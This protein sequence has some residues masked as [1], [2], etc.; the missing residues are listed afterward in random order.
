MVQM[1]LSVAFV[2]AA[3]AIVPVVALPY[4]HHL[5]GDHNRNNHNQHESAAPADPS[6]PATAN[7]VAERRS[8][9]D[10]EILEY[11]SFSLWLS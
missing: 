7:S 5:H 11:V 3:A 9:G 6:P 8:F 2:L 10:Y 1:K 4:G